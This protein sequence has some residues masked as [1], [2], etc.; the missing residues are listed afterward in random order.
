MVGSGE[1]RE[2]LV[3]E[4]DEATVRHTHIVAGAL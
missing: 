4:A 1:L 3:V 2:V